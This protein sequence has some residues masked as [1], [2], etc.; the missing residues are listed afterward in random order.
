MLRI[1]ARCLVLKGCPAS[2][3]ILHVLRLIVIDKR[4]WGALAGLGKICC[5]V[6]MNLATVFEVEISGAAAAA[7]A[8]APATAART[9][10]VPPQFHPR[11]GGAPDPA[12]GQMHCYRVAAPAS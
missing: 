11:L 5:K 6:H 1:T 4:W 2:V 7:R 9:R 3:R 8:L 10:F 12:I